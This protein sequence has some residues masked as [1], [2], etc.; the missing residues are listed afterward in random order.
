MHPTTN[1]HELLNQFV[2]SK[3]ATSATFQDMA[4]GSVSNAGKYGMRNLL[5]GIDSLTSKNNHLVNPLTQV[6]ENK[7]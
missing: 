3:Q 1:L 2:Q 4:Y 6:K 5:G 7:L